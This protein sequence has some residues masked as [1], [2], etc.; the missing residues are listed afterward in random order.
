VVGYETVVDAGVL[1]PAVA[2]VQLPA[3]QGGMDLPAAHP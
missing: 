1:A 3:E 2:L